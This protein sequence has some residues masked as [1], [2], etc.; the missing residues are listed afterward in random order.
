MSCTSQSVFCCILRNFAFAGKSVTTPPPLPYGPWDH[1]P[2]HVWTDQSNSAATQDEAE[3]EAQ[4]CVCCAVRSA[5][6]SQFVMSVRSTIVLNVLTPT[7]VGAMLFV[8][9]NTN[10]SWSG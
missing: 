7:I 3:D 5:P 10:D 9:Y 8:K 2:P 4:V 6:P 1:V